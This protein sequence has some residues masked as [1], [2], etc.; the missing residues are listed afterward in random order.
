MDNMMKKLISLSMITAMFVASGA[1]ANGDLR[2]ELDALK[3]EV[4]GLKKVIKK[5]KL[6]KIKKQL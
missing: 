6:K 4:A 5:A 2:V 3:K 1:S